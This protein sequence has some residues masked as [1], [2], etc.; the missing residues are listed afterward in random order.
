MQIIDTQSDDLCFLVL[1]YGNDVLHIIS[2]V[3]KYRAIM[4]GD[5]IKHRLDCSRNISNTLKREDSLYYIDFIRRDWTVMVS[6]RNEDITFTIK[7]SYI[8]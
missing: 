5:S 1:K 4:I 8:L 6:M 2:L 3:K 7:N